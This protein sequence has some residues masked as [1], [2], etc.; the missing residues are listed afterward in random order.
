[1]LTG[2][3]ANSPI[4]GQSSRGLV[5]SRTSQLTDGEVFFEVT[6][7][8]NYICAQNQNLTIILTISTVEN[9]PINYIDS[10]YLL[11][12]LNQTFRRVDQSAT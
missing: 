7:R 8:L 12:V 9:V 2:Q 5:N 3:F 10:N 11:P 6:E 4:R 1:M